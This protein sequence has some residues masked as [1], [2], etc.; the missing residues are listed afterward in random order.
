MQWKHK[1]D[2]CARDGGT[3]DSDVVDGSANGGIVR[4]FAVDKC[5][6]NSGLV[7]RCVV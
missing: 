3:E 4:R 5:I 7:D 6:E 1:V 2:R